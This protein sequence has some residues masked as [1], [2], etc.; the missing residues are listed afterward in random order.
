KVDV[1]KGVSKSDVS[2]EWAVRPH[3]QRYTS[4]DALRDAVALRYQNSKEFRVNSNEIKVNFSPDDSDSL[5]IETE[6]GEAHPSNWAFAQLGKLGGP[7]A[8]A[9]Y[10]RRLPAVIA[11][12]N[13]QY[14]LKYRGEQV[15]T[16]I[17]RQELVDGGSAIELRAAT[18]PDYGRIPDMEVV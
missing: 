2:R 8:P 14:G 15:K 3:D 6:D 17:G 16:Y 5:T 9:A 11:G 4:L 13:L 7:A 10:R 12:L 18:G 1:S